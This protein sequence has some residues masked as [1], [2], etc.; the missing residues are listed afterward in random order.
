MKNII[1][2][3]LFVGGGLLF[4]LC[5]FSGTSGQD[6]QEIFNNSPDEVNSW[7]WWHWMNGNISKRGIT[8]DLEEMKK[9]GFGGA[10]IFNVSDRIPVG[11][12]PFLSQEWMDLT[13]FAI[14][15]AD[16]IGLQIGMHNCP[17]WSASGGPWIEPQNAKKLIVFSEYYSEG[18]KKIEVDL[19]VPIHNLFYEDIKTL[20]FP[21]LKDEGFRFASWREKTGKVPWVLTMFPLT[22]VDKD[23]II[24]SDA[25]VDVSKYMDDYGRLSWEAPKGNWTIVRFGY[26]NSRNLNVQAPA[27]GTGPE[28]DKFDTLAVKTH[29]DAYPRKIIEM[30]RQYAG[31]TFN[32]MVIDSYEGGVQTWTAAFQHEFAKR[33]GYD[34]MPWLP[35]LTGRIVGSPEL[36]DRFLCDYRLTISDL[37]RDHYYGYMRK[38][39]SAYGM[40]LFVEPYG[41]HNVNP[42]D[43][44]SQADLV[45]FEFWIHHSSERWASLTKAIASTAHV[46]DKK[47]VDAEAFTSRPPNV[48]HIT[49]F[50]MK[51]NADRAYIQGL[52]KFTFHSYP[53]QPR[54]DIKPGMSM[55]PHGAFF[56][57]SNTWWEP[58]K[59][60]FGYFS[61]CNAMLQQGLY[62]ADILSYIGDVAPWTSH[63]AES[64]Y[65]NLNYYN[66]YSFDYCNTDVILNR[67]AVKNGKIVLPG[68][69]TYSLLLLPKSNSIDLN[70]LQKIQALVKKG[71]IVVGDR[72]EIS[73]GLK[74][75]P[76]SDAQVKS[77]ASQLWGKTH[78]YSGVNSYGRG[79]VFWGKTAEEVLNELSIAPDF[80]CKGDIPSDSIHFIHRRTED[81]DIYFLANINNDA[82][83][84]ECF[85][86]IRG[87]LPELWNPNT[88]EIKTLT[89]YSKSQD[90]VTI[91]LYF[92]RNG[93]MFIVF[94]RSDKGFVAIENTAL[95]QFGIY[96]TNITL[97]ISDN[98]D[99]W[100]DPA[101]GGVGNVTFEE[102]DS[103]II[104][105]NP[106]IKYYSGTAIYKKIFD[107]P[108]TIIGSRMYLVFDR[109]A[110]LGKV[111][112]NGEE[113]A[114]LWTP[115]YRVDITKNIKSG[116]N[117]IEIS[118]TNTWNN[119]LVGDERYPDDHSFVVSK[120]PRMMGT[121]GITKIPDW[122]I[123]GM[124]KPDNKRVAFTTWKH[125]TLDSP[126]YDAGIIGEVKIIKINS[127]SDE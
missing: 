27:E 111:V 71:M 14:Q 113:C 13:L 12:I 47:I 90:G 69:M 49:P 78:S 59:A 5:T 63:M 125:Y 98:W 109:I 41:S 94:R 25:I 91:P 105:D 7:T 60:M 72:P 19:P 106:E 17:G 3:V 73:Q 126:L 81:A 120:E 54:P 29:F 100:F 6:L 117:T 107:I 102:L 99:V 76:D 22:S 74:G 1:F 20:A 48:F 45:A 86:R 70:V 11:Q 26:T 46:Y 53:H 56:S 35:C 85:F 23:N 87:K 58:G 42:M 64:D 18:G 44:G 123:Q 93:S 103:W 88:G 96:N 80:V 110:D 57:P 82:G 114:I 24:D 92:E 36:T 79:K 39:L 104:N 124:P 97:D 89:V 55:G 34:M 9:A 38:L 16:R 75:Y 32:V 30:A 21:T 77:I 66:G 84:V 112:V 108:E 28:C 118:V 2:I 65:K 52:N 15:E 40:K 83:K 116:N 127:Q 50:D 51:P 95:E 122:F 115:P 67:I 62:V 121:S 68:G 101:M 4:T 10:H 43:I 31:K 33:R 37:Y 61:R 8:N 119:R